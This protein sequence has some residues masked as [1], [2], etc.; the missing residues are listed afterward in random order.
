MTEI[1]LSFCDV[2]LGPT[3]ECSGTTS[4]TVRCR[5]RV[6][7]KL[8]KKKLPRAASSAECLRIMLEII[9]PFISFAL[10]GLDI[11]AR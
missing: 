10:F 8:R 4:D 3:V 6:S 11:T 5:S 7:V 1:R 9:P 2:S